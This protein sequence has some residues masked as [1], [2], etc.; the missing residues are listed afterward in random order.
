MPS[1]RLR[2]NLIARFAIASLLV[3]ASPVAALAAETRVVVRAISK[4]AK[5]IGSSMGGVRIVLRDKQTGA[6]LTTGVT[7]GD[8][9][10]TKVIM[11]TP[12]QHGAAIATA[13]SAKFE[14]VLDLAQPTLVDE[15]WDE[16]WA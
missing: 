15:Q 8:T 2:A 4:D 6:I 13:T 3:A 5:F 11:R 16:R 9:G 12:R 1:K 14:T 7:Q 10:D